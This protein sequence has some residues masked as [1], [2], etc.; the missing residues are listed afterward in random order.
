MMKQ[1]NEKALMYEGHHKTIEQI[2]AHLMKPCA[3][4]RMRF[5]LASRTPMHVDV[6]KATPSVSVMTAK[7]GD[8]F[9]SFLKIIF[10]NLS[11]FSS[12]FINIE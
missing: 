10:M 1:N 6:K 8:F 5:V 7:A 4:A 2:C 3:K 11:L 9:K 12:S